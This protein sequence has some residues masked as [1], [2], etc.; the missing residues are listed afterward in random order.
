MLS[1]ILSVPTNYE[2]LDAFGPLHV[3]W[4]GFFAK[5]SSQPGRL[6]KGR[7]ERQYATTSHHHKLPLIL[8]RTPPQIILRAHSLRLYAY[9]PAT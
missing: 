5:R 9:F 6:D 8:R 3:C 7:L 1:Q 2:D 4:D